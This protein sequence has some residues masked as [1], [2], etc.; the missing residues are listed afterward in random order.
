[1]KQTFI[2][3]EGNAKLIILF[4]GWG[5]DERVFADYRPQQSD[6]LLC[7]DYRSLEFDANLLAP[8]SEVYVVAWSMGV[9]AAHQLFADAQLKRNG[10]IAFNGTPYPVDDE[11]GIA[12]TVYQGTYSG[13]TDVSLWKFFRRMCG[14]AELTNLF[15]QRAPLRSV[16]ELKEELLAIREQHESC[17]AHR[18]C[19]WDKAIIGADDRIFLP[20]NQLKAWQGCAEIVHCDV[21]HYSE[22][23]LRELIES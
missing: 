22:D 11:R 12:S 21:P 17:L 2:V 7:F 8:Y 19:Q 1:M 10:M 5:M 13:L 23:L 16:E 20:D 6:L 9:W 14:S 18:C 3:K 4:A 15:R